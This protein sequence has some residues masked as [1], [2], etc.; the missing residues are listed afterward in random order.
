MY[1]QPK[2]GFALSE[3]AKEATYP[4]VSRPTGWNIRV[5]LGQPK[6]ADVMLLPMQISMCC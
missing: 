6:N 4:V 5:V 2:M 1:L 3:L